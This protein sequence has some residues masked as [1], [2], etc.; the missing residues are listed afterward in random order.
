MFPP[1]PGRIQSHLRI[2]R[3]S[4]SRQLQQPKDEREDP[5]ARYGSVRWGNPNSIAWLLIGLGS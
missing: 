2:R 4:K 3:P 1:H 5:L